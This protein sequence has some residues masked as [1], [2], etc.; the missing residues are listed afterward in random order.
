MHSVLFFYD[1]GSPHLASI[2]RIVTEMHHGS[3]MC[4]P[5]PETKKY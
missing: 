5:G 1:S 3:W 4:L 2:Q